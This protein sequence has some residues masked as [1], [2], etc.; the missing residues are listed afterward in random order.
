MDTNMALTIIGVVLMLVGV[1]FNVIP[2][3]VNKKINPD[4]PAEAE[5]IAAT[6]RV[7]IGGIAI[8][9]GFIVFYCRNLPIQE[10]MTLLYGL[11]IGFI[12]IALCIISVKPRGFDK[13]IAFPPVIMFA[14]LTVV[15]FYTYN[16]NSKVDDNLL[17][18][19]NHIK[20]DKNDEES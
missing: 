19:L 1:I 7:I 18:V 15:A 2:K 9:L 3:Q 5:N 17:I 11:C 12:V 10:A 20:A 4:I 14:I 8:A 16:Y 13:Q 6:F